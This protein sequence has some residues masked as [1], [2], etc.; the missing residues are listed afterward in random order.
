MEVNKSY[1]CVEMYCLK[2]ADEREAI[3]KVIEERKDRVP[4]S[5]CHQLEQC[6]REV[7]VR[8]GEL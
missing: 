4:L 8:A 3:A 1:K 5:V 7:E 2:I 6:I